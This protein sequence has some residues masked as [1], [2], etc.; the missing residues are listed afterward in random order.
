M[1]TLD[2]HDIAGLILAGGRGA[3]LGGADKGLQSFAGQPLVAHAIARLRP[4]VAS[5]LI[6]ANRHLERYAACGFPV[7]VDGDSDYRG[8]LAGILRGLRAAPTA[9]IAVVPCDAPFFPSDL[10]VRLAHAVDS[11]RAAVAKVEGKPQPVFCLLHTSL[12]ADL[13]AALRAGQR[14]TG[15]WLA[16]IGAVPVEFADACS[17]ANLNTTADF[18]AAAQ[19]RQNQWRQN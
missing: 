13:A 8:P 11:A 19:W 10:V 5:L 17:F 3:R 15:A 18:A 1:G 14:T 2:C 7:L 6:S 12:A 4:Q 9:W 16:R